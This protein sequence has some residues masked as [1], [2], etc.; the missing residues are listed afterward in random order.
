MPQKFDSRLSRRAFVAGL[1]LFLAACQSTGTSTPS[2]SLPAPAAAPVTG[3]TP[4]VEGYGAI[5]TE[6]WPIAAID[7]T[8]VDPRYLRQVVSNPTREKPG[9]I[10]VDTQNKF[11]YLV[12]EGGTARRYGVGVGR[13]GFSWDGRAIIDRKQEWPKW[14]PPKEMMERDP[15]AAKW[16]EGMPGGITN[17]LGP[18]ALYL[19]QNGKDTY[20]R[21]HGTTQPNSIGKAMS[22]GCIRLFNQ[23][24]IDLYNRV[25]IGTEVV[26]LQTGV[27]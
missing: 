18:R 11:L 1:P 9:T 7:T 17:P 26:V 8:K 19:A 16:P 14:H 5:T 22:S 4:V 23:D 25:P 20:F 6:P 24:I 15:E 3:R 13:Q 10:V 12:E 2:A 21:I 27:A